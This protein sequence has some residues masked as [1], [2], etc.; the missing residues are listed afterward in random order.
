[1]KKITGMRKRRG[2]QKEEGECRNVKGKKKGNKECPKK[3]QKEG[4]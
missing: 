2:M 1:M 3:E 4:E